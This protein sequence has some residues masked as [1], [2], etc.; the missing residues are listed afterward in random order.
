[1]TEKK[2]GLNDK[3]L[4]PAFM[5]SAP[6]STTNTAPAPALQS[7]TL[8]RERNSASRVVMAGGGDHIIMRDYN[9]TKGTVMTLTDW[10]GGAWGPASAT[11]PIE[12]SDPS[13]RREAAELKGRLDHMD[14]NIVRESIAI[15]GEAYRVTR[16][17]ES[18]R[19]YAN[20]YN[21]KEGSVYHQEF[22]DGETFDISGKSLSLKNL[23]KKWNKEALELETR[24]SKMDSAAIAGDASDVSKKPVYRPGQNQ[25]EKPHGSAWT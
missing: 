21:F 6:K 13:V 18:G 1:M 11:I 3:E 14:K 12:K 17:P 2:S 20:A 25:S 7:E 8:D 5:A 15:N 24:L 22:N 9:F 4:T 19:I 16:N 10:G 23:D